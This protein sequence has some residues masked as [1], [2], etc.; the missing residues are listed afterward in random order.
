MK[1]VVISVKAIILLSIMAIR[2]AVDEQSLH[3][4]VWANYQQFKNN[5]PQAKQSY[6]SLLKHEKSPYVYKGYIHLLQENKSWKDIVDLIPKLDAVFNDDLEIQMIFAQALE[7][8]GKSAE[9]DERLIKINEKN[10]NNQEIA[11][12]TAQSYLRRKEPENSLKVIDNFLNSVPSRPNNFIFYFIKSQI[13]VQMNQKKQALEAVQKSVE[14]YPK[15]DKSW[16]M[17]AMLEEQ[18]GRIEQAIKG[19]TN[20]LQ[21]TDEPSEMVE[22]HLVNLALQHNITPKKL[23]R[24]S[25]FEQALICAQKKEHDKALVIVNDCLKMEPE[26]KQYRLFKLDMLA[27]L[28]KHKDFFDTL[29]LWILENPTQD[30][31]YKALHLATKQTN[32]YALAIDVLKSVEQKHQKNVLP[33]LYLADLYICIKKEA[34]ALSA[35]KKAHALNVDQ[36]IKTKILYQM[37]LIYYDKRQF[38]IMK[39]ILLE[40]QASQTL[41]LPALNLLAY[42]YASKENNIDAAS[43]LIEQVLKHDGTNPHYLD[44]KAFILY[45]QADYAGAI[46]ILEKIID[47]ASEDATILR[48]MAKALYKQGEIH[49][50]NALI[51]QALQIDAPAHEKQKLQKIAQWGNKK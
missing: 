48:H 36:Q 38:K 11:F 22:K 26:N 23:E 41:F 25:S 37:A 46:A 39:K 12:A 27:T 34:A 10:K 33:I 17:L 21:E 18:E 30:L 8:S 9:C 32:S 50:A 4:Y 31:W 28:E 47:Q 1:R 20:F 44:T 7:Q 15:F 24:V 45:K 13:Y 35:L 43:L 5:F 3:R 49:R 6:E 40:A 2:A 51:Q 16:L 14:L 42:Y 19:Y 29:K